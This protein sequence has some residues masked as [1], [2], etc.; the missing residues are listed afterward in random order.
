MDFRGIS[1]FCFPFYEIYSLI[2]GLTGVQ[3]NFSYF[4]KSI[5]NRKKLAEAEVGKSYF[6]SCNLCKNS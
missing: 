3:D 1:Y 4:N 5:T 6:M 2:R